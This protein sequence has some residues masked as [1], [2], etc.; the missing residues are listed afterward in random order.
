MEIPRIYYLDYFAK[1]SWNHLIFFYKI[2]ILRLCQISCFHEIFFKWDQISLSQLSV[3]KFKKKKKDSLTERIF[4]K[5][6][7]VKMLLSRNFCQKCLRVNFRNLRIAVKILS[8]KL[9]QINFTLNWFHEKKLC[10]SKCIV[11]PHCTVWELCGKT[12]VLL[13]LIS[14]YISWKQLTAHFSNR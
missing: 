14:Y 10:G 5:S 4:V 9:R 3:E 8:Q 12:R 11:F 1:S 6:T 7:L 2:Y 13:R